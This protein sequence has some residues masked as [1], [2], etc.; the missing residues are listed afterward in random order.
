M[1]VTPNG[2]VLP[3]PAAAAIETLT[4][5]NVRDRPLAEIWGESE[6][7]TRYRGTQWMPDPCR[8]CER[9]EI[10]WGGCRCQAYLLAGD[11]GLTDPACSLS[12]AHHAVVALRDGSSQEVAL[13]A[14]RA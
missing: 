7:F 6:S 10:D 13:V 3:C 1:T 2:Q 11:A 9:R 8:S 4:F 12:P 14:R 5:E